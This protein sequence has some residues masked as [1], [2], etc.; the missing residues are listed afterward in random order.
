MDVV[1]LRRALSLRRPERIVAM[2]AA[3]L[4]PTTALVLSLMRVDRAVGL[5]LRLPGPR[6]PLPITVTG[7]LVD[8]VTT[9]LGAS[10]LVRAIVLHAV[11]A[12]QG[13]TS[14]VVIGAAREGGRL[15]AHAWVELDGRV[16]SVDGRGGCAPLYRVQAGRPVR[17]SA[18]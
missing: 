5:L 14:A 17:V 9:G 12:R 3:A 10:C 2:Q 8:A 11:L 4:V 13:R 7:R 16:V 1:R 18:A 6:A 15:R